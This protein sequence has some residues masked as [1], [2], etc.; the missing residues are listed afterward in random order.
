MR[1]KNESNGKSTFSYDDDDGV[2][3]STRK[4]KNQIKL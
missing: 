4:K 2:I 3:A 1:I